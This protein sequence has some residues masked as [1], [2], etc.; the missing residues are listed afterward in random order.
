[1][2]LGVDEQEAEAICRAA[3]PPRPYPAVQRGTSQD[4]AAPG[5]LVAT[6]R[7]IL[8]LPRVR[9]S[10]GGDQSSE[11]VRGEDGRHD[12]NRTAPAWRADSPKSGF[13]R[14]KR[15]EQLL[16]PLGARV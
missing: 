12:R 5:D 8:A 11:G 1:M 4:P 10:P 2:I 16:S 6:F 14:G 3:A 13:Q 7:K 15:R 9:W